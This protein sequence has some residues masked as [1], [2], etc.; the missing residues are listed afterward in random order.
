MTKRGRLR[1]R[2]GRFR[3]SR[4]TRKRHEAERRAGDR[5]DWKT[6]KRLMAQHRREQRRMYREALRQGDELTVHQVEVLLGEYEETEEEMDF[7]EPVGC[8]P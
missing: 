8:Y 7:V 6:S 3:T 5:F 2:H 1:T 4:E